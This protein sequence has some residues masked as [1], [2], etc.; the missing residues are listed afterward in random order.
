MDLLLDWTSDCADLTLSRADL[1]TE[2]GLQSACI[3]SL[4]TDARC[5]A[6]ELPEGETDSRG[7]WGDGLDGLDGTPVRRG[8]KL[9]L[10]GREKQVERTRQ[11]AE[12]YAAAALQWL[13]TDG[14][15]KAVAVSA[16]WEG[17]GLLLLRVAVTLPDSRIW[18]L[19]N[20]V[21]TGG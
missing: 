2:Q 1:A 12:E 18:T 16:S 6:D 13:V 8:S 11:R 15:A 19:Q 17:R 3:L 4:F 7:W 10:L 21:S 5:D 20:T 9:W 14:H